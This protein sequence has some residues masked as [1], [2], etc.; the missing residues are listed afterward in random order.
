M[1]LCSGRGNNPALFGSRPQ[2]GGILKG[3]TFLN[4][5]KQKQNRIESIYVSYITSLTYVGIFHTEV[6]PG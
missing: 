1:H 3:S 6:K 4:A 5:A 2:R